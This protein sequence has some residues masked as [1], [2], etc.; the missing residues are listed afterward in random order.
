MAINAIN[1]QRSKPVNAHLLSCRDVRGAEHLIGQ[2]LRF[3]AALLFF[4][5]LSPQK[6]L[7]P[8]LTPIDIFQGLTIS[9]ERLPS[10]SFTETSN[11]KMVS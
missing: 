10:R 5:K 7:K 4:L 6:L 3:I 11:P 9:T 1:N 2:I 8:L